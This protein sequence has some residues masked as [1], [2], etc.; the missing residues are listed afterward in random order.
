MKLSGPLQQTPDA[1]APAERRARQLESQASGRSA[2]D[3]TLAER[4]QELACACPPDRDE[5]ATADRPLSPD[6]LRRLRGAIGTLAEQSNTAHTEDDGPTPVWREQL[7][8]TL[9]PHWPCAQAEFQAERGN[10]GSE[11]PPSRLQRRQPADLLAGITLRA[12]PGTIADAST[13]TSGLPAKVIDQQTHFE[14]TKIIRGGR[15]IQPGGPDFVSPIAQHRES[16]ASRFVTSPQIADQNVGETHTRMDAAMTG[17]RPPHGAD[18]GKAAEQV[19]VAI[20][21]SFITDSAQAETAAAPR[22][23]PPVPSERPPGAPLRTLVLH[24]QPEALGAVRIVMRS[25]AKTLS[26]RLEAELGE[27]ASSLER[28]RAVMTERIADAGYALDEM[29]I[30]RTDDSP[31]DLSRSPIEQPNGRSPDGSSGSPPGSMQQRRQHQAADRA[32]TGAL[33]NSGMA[34]EVGK[35][36]DPGHSDYARLD[37]L[38]RRS[39]RIV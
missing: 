2:F 19:A 29:V 35:A 7:G 20:V 38:G 28:D 30:A 24:L 4:D 26:V 37:H 16:T 11:P 13:A 9:T 34:G 31:L 23:A 5:V 15:A 18:T 33:T 10:A 36:A 21:D 3:E 39:R 6:K 14:P 22:A 8:A 25:N 27:T 32:T 1:V 12:S 17:L